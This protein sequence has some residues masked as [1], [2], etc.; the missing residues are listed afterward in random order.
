MGLTVGTWKIAILGEVAAPGGQVFA[1]S[2][3]TDLVIE[4]P[5]LNMTIEMAAI[6]RGKEGEVYCK[7]ETLREFEGEADIR[8]VALPALT[9][10]VPLKI[11]KDT[12]EISFPVKT[13]IKAR[14]ATTKNLFISASIPVADTISAR[15]LLVVGKSASI[16]HH[17][18]EKSH[19][20]A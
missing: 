8:L 13:E 12:K 1:S 19:N 5:Y 2:R 4:E 14:A 3:L 16:T 7:I 10:T 9:S 6:E 20:K 11:N 18:S 15:Q 17:S